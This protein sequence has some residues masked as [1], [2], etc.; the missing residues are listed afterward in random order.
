MSAIEDVKARLDIVQVVSEY[1]SLEKAGRNFRASCPF[2]AERT[3]S[4]YVFPDRGTWRCFGACAEGGDM[5]SF[6]MKKEDIQFGEALEKLA[7]R[8]GV[9]LP[10]KRG[11]RQQ[12]QEEDRLATVNALAADYFHTLLLESPQGAA[13]RA[14]LEKRRI[15]RKAIDMFK[16]GVGPVGW[17]TLKRHLAELGVEESVQL[18]AGLLVESDKGTTYDRF[19]E[20]VTFPIWN[21]QGQVVGFGARTLGEDTPKYVNTPQT[22]L[23]DKGSV[24]YGIDKAVEGIKQA[25]QA[26]IVE[27]YTDVIQAHRHGFP[28]VVAAMGTALTERQVSLLR[29]LTNRF[30]LALAPDAAGEKATRRSLE[31]SWNVFQ[32]T[33]RVGAGKTGQFMDRQGAP[34][35]SVVTLPDGVDPAEFIQE[36]PDQ[37]RKRLAEAQS[38]LEYLFAWE[39]RQADA[40][41]PAGKQAMVERLFPLIA[42]LENPFEQDRYFKKLADT[43]DVNERTLAA[44]VGRPQVQRVRRQ[45][46]ATAPAATREA[47][48]AALEDAHRDRLEEHC[49]ALLLR[50]PDLAQNLQG[51]SA[52]HFQRPENREVYKTWAANQGSD[53][54]GKIDEALTEHVARLQQSALPVSDGLA[55]QKVFQSC[56]LRLEERHLRAMKEE[57]YALEKA[58]DGNFAQVND[59]ETALTRNARLNALFARRR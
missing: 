25:G 6:V 21:R 34:D 29:A 19:R 1:V 4:F 58:E 51:L 13:A 20:R 44:I 30:V 23:F 5:F 11:A 47:S 38:L 56:V 28:N 3:P 52:E 50:H 36:D 31:S 39:A 10:D 14:Y 43:L 33:V 41:G 8:S 24:L 32:K 37:W 22:P 54:V 35:I 46:R 55:Y 12:A 18:K 27:G 2:H 48:A 16:L 15:D 26:V 17:D 59:R 49:L 53:I 40:Q 42:A 7:A 57:E 9:Q 45:V